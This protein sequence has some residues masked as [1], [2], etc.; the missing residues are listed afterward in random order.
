MPIDDC[1]AEVIEASGGKLSKEDAKE[2]LEKFNNI[3]KNLP[4]EVR[5]RSL[6]NLLTTARENMVIRQ[7][8]FNLH[9]KR[10]EL[11]AKVTESHITAKISNLMGLKTVK[12]NFKKAFTAL[13]YGTPEKREGLVHI[14]QGARSHFNTVL[15][16]A[17]EEQNLNA[18]WHDNETVNQAIRALWNPSA[19]NVSPEAQSIA[20]ILARIQKLSVRR[21]NEAGSYVLDSPLVLCNARVGDAGKVRLMGKD[22]FVNFVKGLDLDRKY[23]QDWDEEQ[24]DTYFENM[25]DR[26]AS[27]G[28]YQAPT[29][30]F[31]GVHGMT[32]ERYKNE[33]AKGSLDH[34]IPFATPEAYMQFVSELSDEP[35]QSLLAR[36]IDQIG[37]SV[38][39]MEAFGPTP[40]RTLE[41]VMKH[42]EGSMSPD[43]ATFLLKVPQYKPPAKNILDLAKKGVKAGKSFFDFWHD[44][45]PMDALREMDGSSSAPVDTS[46]AR[47]GAGARAWAT[48]SSLPFG[49]FSQF[50]DNAT[51]IAMLANYGKDPFDAIMSPLVELGTTFPSQERK[52]FYYR[53]GVSADLLRNN[54][55]HQIGEVGYTS[56][57]LA[58]AMDLYFKANGMAWKDRV[59]KQ[60][61]A[62]FHSS[63]L[64]WA[65]NNEHDGKNIM[66]LWRSYGFT[67]EDFA[68]LRTMTGKVDDIDV[69]DPKA[70]HDANDRLY[71]RY[72]GTMYDIINTTTPTPGIREKAA[73]HKGTRPGTWDGEV[74][75]I[76]GMFKNY[77]AMLLTRV[78][79][80]I[81][82]EHGIQGTLT[83]M[84][85]MMMFWYLGDSLKSLAQGKTPR[86]MTNPNNVW[87]ALQR[88]GLG[89][90][91]GDMIA[92]DYSRYGTDIWSV[93]GGPLAGKLSDVADLGS[94]AA[95]GKLT[96][97]M[98]THK[99]ERMI[100][101]VHMGST[102]LNRALQYGILESAEPGYSAKARQRLQEQTG[103]QQLF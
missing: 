76:S 71:E 16:L 3:T 77:P 84:L 56:K 42:F 100:P 47:L 64:A 63:Q 67:D 82:Y 102:I 9:A 103:Q 14:W 21:L 5:L 72:I 60:H 62:D 94:T 28:Q 45:H 33:A 81:H 61:T 96:A 52:L 86:D 69:V 92:N 97:N 93:I 87:V 74:L 31:D 24:L 58:A 12:K 6:D 29:G 26:M 40:E 18:H 85:G 78:Y 34:E 66:D 68:Q 79:P 7:D 54:L 50:N 88:S 80:L 95:Q 75:R 101:N 44:A 2:L 46:L 99:L 25:Y 91:Y 59:S 4:P 35:I 51:K 1:I 37:R 90:I 83:T 65:L 11:H 19:K 98:A 73:Q 32:K 38:G 39:L 57:R 53:L 8:V 55:A 49:M 22:G 70:I 41:R 10:M 30:T 89:G 27:G 15:P 43:D 13:F 48:M 36:R 23:F 17:L 20:G